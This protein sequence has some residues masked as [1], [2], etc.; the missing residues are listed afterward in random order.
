MKNLITKCSFVFVILFNLHLNAQEPT[1][2]SEEQK[3]D[4]I[5]RHPIYDYGSKELTTTDTIPDF[6]NK[7]QKLKISGTVYTSDGITPAKDV[8]IYIEQ[9]DENGDFELRME[10]DKR[11]VYHRG[12]AITNADGH[13]TFYTF[14]PGNDRR[15]NQLQQLFPTVKAPSKQAYDLESF[16]FD[17]DPLLTKLCR[18]K[19][20]KKGDVTRI[21]KPVTKD[22]LLIVEK[23]IVLEDTMVSMK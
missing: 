8:I 17:D 23:N 1:Q 18:K 11:Y 13:Y 9:A 2:I 7:Q 12:W 20:T 22:D 15:Y 3:E 6:V 19:I 10:N 14:L 16:L 4:Y 21:L 5:D